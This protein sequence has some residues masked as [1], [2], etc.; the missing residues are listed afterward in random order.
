M[1]GFW[2]ITG[3]SM[4]RIGKDIKPLISV[5]I[6]AFKQEDTIVKDV[7]RIEDVLGRIGNPYEI[8]VVVDGKVDRTFE[9][10]S[11]IR[12][13][14]V[15]IL[16]YDE[17]RGKGYAIRL[18][19][20]HTRG[21]VVGF[22]DAGMDIHPSGFSMLLNHMEWY[23]ADIIVGSKRHPVSK[24]NYPLNRRLI[25]YLSQIFIRFLFGLNIR[26]TQVGLKFF[27]R[28]VIEKVI[29]RLLVKHY[30]FDI[31]ILVVASHLGFKRIFEAP[32][33][34][35]WTMGSGI[36]TGNL[37]KVLL[38]TF[39]DTLSIFYRLKLQNFYDDENRRK[40]KQIQ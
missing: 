15:K 31:E 37:W 16:G 39:W 35:R 34:L 17:N 13:K 9:R 30:A 3:I 32:I 18:G 6:P 27:K 1:W 24:V 11:K 40:W 5:I 25:S 8:I 12:S 26:D 10:V 2:Y 20:K 29:Q 38:L 14:T 28:K 7:K 36:T 4:G 21:D 23:N 22:I 33:K 19:M